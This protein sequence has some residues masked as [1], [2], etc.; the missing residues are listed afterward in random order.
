LLRFKIVFDIVIVNDNDKDDNKVDV[1]DFLVV[2]DAVMISYKEFIIVLL[3]SSN[4]QL[5]M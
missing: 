3:S 1:V 5:Y 2:D 4:M